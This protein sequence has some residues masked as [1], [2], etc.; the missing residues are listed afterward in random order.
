MLGAGVALV[1]AGVGWW[2]G[3]KHEGLV[4]RNGDAKAESAATST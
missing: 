1:W 4:A 2:L 3:K